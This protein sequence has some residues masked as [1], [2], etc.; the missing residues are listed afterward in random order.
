M[1]GEDQIRL[2]VSEKAGQTASQIAKHLGL[3]KGTVSSFLLKEVEAGRLI[4]K[5]SEGPRGGYGYYPKA[6]L[7][8]PKEPE[9]KFV[10]TDGY[11]HKDPNGQFWTRVDC[12]Q[13]SS[14]TE[15]QLLN[16]IVQLAEEVVGLSKNWR[17]CPSSKDLLKERLL[18]LQR[19]RVR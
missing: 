4:R 14:P 13:S 7:T 9:L 3:K 19:L 10:R 15:Q 8:T 1:T 17:F 5:E 18:D 6:V 2:C 16:K 12:V 11:G